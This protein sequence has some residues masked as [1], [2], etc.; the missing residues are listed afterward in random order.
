MLRDHNR[1]ASGIL[2]SK[3]KLFAFIIGTECVIFFFLY[4]SYLQIAEGWPAG[5]TEIFQSRCIDNENYYKETVR[6][7]A[8][9]GLIKTGSCHFS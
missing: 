6:G 8:R 5:Q 4:F 3:R 2:R 9:D 7:I 1:F